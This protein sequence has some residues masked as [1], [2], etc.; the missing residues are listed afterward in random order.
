M[1]YIDLSTA[2][3]SSE[4]STWQTLIYSLWAVSSVVAL[5]LYFKFSVASFPPIVPGHWVFK[6]R[7]LVGAP[8]RGILIAEKYKPIYGMFLLNSFLWL[9]LWPYYHRRY[10]SA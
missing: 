10:P 2:I 8:W 4:L 5:Y 3:Y 1:T 6:N 7:Q 9:I